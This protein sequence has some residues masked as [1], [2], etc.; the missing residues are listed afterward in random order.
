M[1]YETKILLN[2]LIETVGSPDWRSIGIASAIAIV[3]AGFMIWIGFRQSKL[4]E[5]QL[6]IQEHQNEL[7]EQQ[8]AIQHRQLQLEKFNIQRD[9]YRNLYLLSLDSRVVLP[10]VY[11][12]FVVGS[13]EV[14]L[15]R[16][17]KNNADFERLARNI[18]MS[19]ADYLLQYGEND[20][21]VDTRYFAD[22]ISFIFGKVASIHIE[23]Q[24]NI[25]T[26]FER[27]Q[28][29]NNRWS[30]R[31]WVENIKEKY[32]DDNLISMLELFVK[33]K[34]RLFE[35]ENSVLYVVK[36]RIKDMS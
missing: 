23:P 12:Y 30:D 25:V 19:E 6:K 17:D 34:H 8:N 36:E 14:L 10:L 7:Q 35:G 24:N 1:D 22:A 11:E 29:R 3:N 33:E 21:I 16:F 28:A 20:I 2:K 27:M 9:I 13:T 31:E 4:Q 26:L 5:Q 15:N 32:P 18:E